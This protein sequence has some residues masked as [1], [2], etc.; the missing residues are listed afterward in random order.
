MLCYIREEIILSTALWSYGAWCPIST[1]KS[2]CSSY[3]QCGNAIYKKRCIKSSCFLLYFEAE[4][5]PWAKLILSPLL[6]C[7]LT[8][9]TLHH[10]YLHNIISP[11]VPQNTRYGPH[12]PFQNHVTCGAQWPLWSLSCTAGD[13]QLPDVLDEKW[14]SE[15]L[16]CTRE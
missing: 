16:F 10:I 4:A 15:A 1:Y 14:S 2:V 11:S 3:V 7:P 6:Q 9:S 13:W 5:S 8:Q 12:I